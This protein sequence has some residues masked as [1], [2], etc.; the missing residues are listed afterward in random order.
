MTNANLAEVGMAWFSPASWEQLRA[1][2]E[3]E[4][5]GSYDDFVRKVERQMRAF[6][7]RGFTVA[8]VVVDVPHMVAWCRRHGLRVTSTSRAKYGAALLAAGG[9]RDALDR[10]PLEQ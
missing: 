2:A 3:D 1:V 6:E 8:K 5:T 10:M 9:D 4:L 7:A